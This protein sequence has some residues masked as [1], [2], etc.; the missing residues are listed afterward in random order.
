[1]PE[2]GWRLVYRTG[3]EAQFL[4]PVDGGFAYA[5]VQANP[6]GQWRAETWGSCEPTFTVAGRKTARWWLA[7]GKP[8]APDDRTINV[9]VVDVCNDTALDGRLD[10]P[11]IRMTGRA[12][13]A[14]FTAAPAP[15]RG[16]VCWRSIPFA[17]TITLHG[18]LGDR[19][20]LDGA[21]WPARDATVPLP[22]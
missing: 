14:I 13:L 2:R 20:L 12:V 11:V 18:P 10:K 1:M 17:T 5:T 6:D 22:P 8:P 16:D 15:E 7:P 9:I 4:A 19:L 21:T 3:V